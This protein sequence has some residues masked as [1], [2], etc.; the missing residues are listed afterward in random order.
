VL[1]I[2]NLN[3]LDLKGINEETHFKSMVDVKYHFTTTS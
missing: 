1:N 2:A 3:G